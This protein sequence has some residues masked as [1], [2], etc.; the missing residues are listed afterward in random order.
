MTALT[1]DYIV[2]FLT[3]KK[4]E[5]LNEEEDNTN[6]NF[7]QKLHETINSKLFPKLFSEFLMDN[8]DRCGVVQC[9]SSKNNISGYSSILSI[10]SNAFQIG[11]PSDQLLY[12][13]LLKEKLKSDL[14]KEKLAQ[15]FGFS[16]LGWTKKMLFNEI[17]SSGISN[18]IIY[19]LACYFDINIFVFDFGNGKVYSFYPEDKLN[20]YKNNVLLAFYNE[21]FEPIVYKEGDIRMFNYNSTIFNNILKSGLVIPVNVSKNKKGNKKLLLEKDFSKMIDTSILAGKIVVIENI[22]DE[23]EEDEEDGGDEEDEEDEYSYEYYSDEEDDDEEGLDYHTYSVSKLNKIKKDE[24]INILNRYGN[25][26]DVDLTTKTKKSLI[27][28]IKNKK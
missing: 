19:Y 17:N 14:T 10:L 2:S 21:F 4:V 26:G 12:V 24:L 11:Q 15:K 13:K 18:I 8:V 1:L 22:K 6:M 16:K 20:V 23:D 3:G 7:P 9:K 25:N 5:P 28:M 27:N